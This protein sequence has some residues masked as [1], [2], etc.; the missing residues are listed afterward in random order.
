[1]QPIQGP[2]YRL[3]FDLT[4]GSVLV[5]D[6]EG[7][8]FIRPAYTYAGDG[9]C[10]HHNADCLREPKFVEA[11][12]KGMFSGH[13][14]GGGGDLHIEWR[15]HQYCWAGYHAMH[16]DGDFVECGVNTGIFSLAIM[17]YCDFNQSN[18]K[19]YLFDT[20]E[21]IPEEQYTPEERAIG[22]DKAHEGSYFDCYDIAKKN[23]APYSGAVLVQGRVPESL[24]QVN[25]EKVAYVGIDMNSVAPEIAAAEHFWPKMVP[26]AVMMLDDYGWVH[27]RYQKEAFDRFAAE[28]GVKI[29]NLPTGQGLLIKP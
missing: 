9:Y 21:G 6:A 7:N 22:L 11:Y 20:F 13:K 8:R 3:E 1:M 28:R 25:I 19:F 2:K 15:V 16:L 26:G 24:S 12:Q 10:T 18:K 14:I 4:D 5:N 23:F 29:L 17:H 27:H